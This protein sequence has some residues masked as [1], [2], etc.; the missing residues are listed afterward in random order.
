[1]S[2]KSSTT[3][4]E[5]RTERKSLEERLIRRTKSPYKPN[6]AGGVASGGRKGRE[7]PEKLQRPEKERVKKEETGA[8]ANGEWQPGEH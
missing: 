2:R 8:S 5:T 6:D 3:T 4:T 1:M 7:A